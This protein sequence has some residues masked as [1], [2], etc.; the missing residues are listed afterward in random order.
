MKEVILNM[1]LFSS[2]FIVLFV[3][4]ELLYHRFNVKAEYTRKLVHFGTGLL[5]M[6]FPSYLSSHWQVLLLCLS[7]LLLLTASKKFDLLKSING[8]DRKTFGAVLFPVVVYGC[9]AASEIMN[10]LLF[11]YIPILILAISDPIAALIG[12]KFP[13]GK[14]T[15]LDHTK[16]LSGSIGFFASAFAI[17]FFAMMP[18]MYTWSMNGLM[19]ISLLAGAACLAEA[20]SKDGWDN[21]T[22]PAAVSLVL[23]NLNFPGIC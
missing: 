11:Y 13:F 15:I 14:Y 22:I 8:V 21:F 20:L 16:T 3:I 19:T 17:S 4:A 9:M 23:I 18:Y 5:T 1:S 7:F 10:N 6:F 2:A 12:K